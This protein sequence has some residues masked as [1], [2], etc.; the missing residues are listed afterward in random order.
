MG[1]YLE[2]FKT[3][4]ISKHNG[5]K[6]QWQPTLGHCVLKASLSH[7]EKELQVSLFQTLVLLLFNSIDLLTFIDIREQTGIGEWATPP[8]GIL[9]V[10]G[11]GGYSSQCTTNSKMCPSECPLLSIQW[12]LSISGHSAMFFVLCFLLF[13]CCF[14]FW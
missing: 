8:S 1:K 10:G 6:L 9:C 11:R 12:N 7:G 13:C 14:V 3:F 5:R 2:T 4:Y